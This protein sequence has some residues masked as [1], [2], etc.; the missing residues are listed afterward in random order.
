MGASVQ[1]VQ[2]PSPQEIARIQ[3]NV[4]KMRS[5]GAPESDV[6]AY[7]QHEDSQASAAP[8]MDTS[9]S[10]RNL[11]RSAMQGATF[12]FGDEI[13]LTDRAKEN[14]FKAEHPIAD[15]LAKLGGG[16]VAPVAAVMA[17]PVLGTSALGAA[18]LGA[19]MG[20]LTGAGEADGSMT[21][22]AKGAIQGGLLGAGGGVAG[23]GAGKLL[24]GLASK[25]LDRAYPERAVARSASSI[26]TPNVASKMADVNAIAPGGASIATASVPQSGSKAPAMLP[27][28]RA[29]GANP[30]AASSAEASIVGQKAALKA[31]RDAIGE[32]MD[33]LKG[34]IPITPEARGV[35]AAARELLGAKGPKVPD[36]AESVDLNGLGLEKSVPFSFDPEKK[37]VDVQELRDALSR[38]KFMERQAVKRGVDAQGVT[39]HDI[40]QARAGLQ[41]YIYEHVPGFEALDRPYAIASDQLGQAEKALK[42]VQSSRAN[43]AANKAMG[44]TSGSLGGSLPRGSHGMIMD[45]LDK[46][47]TDKAG[48]AD[49][50]AQMIAKPG[51]PEMVRNILSK[52]PSTRPSKIPPGA[53]IGGLLS[54]QLR[55]LLSPASP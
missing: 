42:T 2:Q 27:M 22:R 5:M 19:G 7:L 35:F 32:K 28:L 41:S 15:L 25:A 39:L 31:A 20:L 44:A 1:P 12:G 47:F 21:D 9:L 53:P 45:L 29:V 49:A 48:A 43:Y 38:L 8:A 23:Y 16:A 30:K 34:E 54:S 52:A 37:T 4:V 13:G 33:A 10:L 3:A 24:G 26:L 6:V 40:A 11:G 36:A 17:A 14:A 18:G 46:I 51:G 55:G 50:V